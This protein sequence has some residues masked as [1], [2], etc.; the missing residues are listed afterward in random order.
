MVLGV[1]CPHG[2]HN[3]PDARFCSVCGTALTEQHASVLISGPRPP[4]GVLV[5]DDGATLAID[6]DVLIGREPHG[7]SE[8]L[9]GAAEPLALTDANNSV[10]RRHA[11]IVLDEWRVLASD[12]GSSNGTWLNRGPDPLSWIEIGSDE[13]VELHAGDRL[14]VGSRLVQVEL[15]HSGANQRM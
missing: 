12:L 7:E 1:V 4:L 15:H 9:A 3:H 10:S 8:V 5:I 2:H 11:R 6:R 14:R 13:Q